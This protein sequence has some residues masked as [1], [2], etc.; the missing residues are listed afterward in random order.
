M[1]LKESI[2]NFHNHLIEI[3]NNFNPNDP[4]VKKINR[5]EWKFSV[6]DED[7]YIFK[8][9]PIWMK[10]GRKGFT[11]EWGLVTDKGLS[12]KIVGGKN[13]KRE[14]FRKVLTCLSQFI[15]SEKPEV[16]S[17]YVSG[18]LVH[19]Y[20]AM[21]A[22]HY[23]NKPFNKYYKDSEEHKMLDGE[24]IYI[25]YFNK[26]LD[27]DVSEDSRTELKRKMLLGRYEGVLEVAGRYAD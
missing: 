15:Y 18:R 27:K 3:A 14:V 17:M 20:D 1:R 22:G 11:I 5:G 9:S 4:N 6:Q 26:K 23:K 2:D 21:W 8:V 16:F 12:T 7:N 24:K 19:I 10:D 25:H 13:S